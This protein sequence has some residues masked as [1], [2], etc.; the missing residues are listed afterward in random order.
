LRSSDID[1]AYVH[2]YGFPRHQGGPMFWA[3]RRGWSELL[4][5]V[6][7]YHASQGATWAPAPLLVEFANKARAFEPA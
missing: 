5:T 3:E 2:G 1:V 4:Q 6:R 7:H